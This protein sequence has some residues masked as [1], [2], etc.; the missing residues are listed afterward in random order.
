MRKRSILLVLAALALGT[1]PAGFGGTN[2]TINLGTATDF[3]LLAGS[4]I[5][6]VSPATFITG[7]VGSSPTP[8]VTGL[9]ASQVNGT[10]YLTASPVTAQAQTDLTV[11]YNQAAGAPCG[12]DLTGIDLGGLTLVPGVY[13]FSSS[14]GLDGHADARRSGECQLAVDFPDWQHPHDRNQFL[15]VPDQRRCA[16][17]CVL[18]GGFLR[19]HPDE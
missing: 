9:L 6:N 16:V 10:L 12:T 14:A 13:C 7:D 19:N 4:G 1:Y 2:V 5:T 18:A 11:G 8:T 17:Q 15:R 3:A